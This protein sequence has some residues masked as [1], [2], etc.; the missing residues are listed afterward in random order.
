M[1]GYHFASLMCR[2]GHEVWGIDDF[3]D[4]YDPELKWNRA[5]NL[6]EL[7]IEVS[8]EDLSH[9]DWGYHLKH[10]AP[11]AVVH[12]A[13][14]A[15]P[16]HSLEHPQLY[17]DVN[18]SATQ[19]LIQACER[20]QIHNVAF[21]SSSCVMEGQP[22]PYRESD[23]PGLLLNPYAWSKRVNESQFAHSKI[24]R[25]AGM[26]FLTVYGPWGRPDM[27]LGLFAEGIANDREIVVNNFGNMKRDWT[28][29]EDAVD[30]LR[31]VLNK[32]TSEPSSCYHEL[33]NVGSGTATNLMDFVAEIELE[34]NKTAKKKMMPLPAGDVI[35]SYADISKISTLG[36][37]PSTDLKTGVAKF[38]QWYRDYYGFGC[39]GRG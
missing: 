19:R 3:N 7:G 25:T 30:S 37:Q 26:R 31:L 21:A 10:R 6:R 23:N 28:Y 16:R 22:L 15:N 2:L 13:A 12:L 33:Y 1:I 24:P 20:Y 5:S 36:Y 27:A 14:Y 34:M 8:D 39:G 9:C 18:I 11:D 4:Y 29:V 32:M 35:E 38:V 17:I